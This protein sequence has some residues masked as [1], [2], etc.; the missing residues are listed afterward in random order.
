MEGK[1]K[2]EGGKKKDVVL[3]SGLNF[4][5]QFRKVLD[6]EEKKTNV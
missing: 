5:W 3:I 4:F 1:V 6:L 2:G